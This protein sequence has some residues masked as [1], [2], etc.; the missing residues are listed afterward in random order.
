MFFLNLGIAIAL[1]LA[2]WFCVFQVFLKEGQRCKTVGLSA[3][4][5]GASS[6]L[7]L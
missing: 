2:K 5:L 1:S 6:D 7:S 3:C 4:S